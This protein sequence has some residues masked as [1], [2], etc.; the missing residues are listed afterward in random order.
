[1]RALD[2]P[3][4]AQRVHGDLHLGQTLRTT[5]GW[6][7]IDFEG[8]PAAPLA[9]RVALDSVWRDVAGMLR[10]FDYAAHSYLVQT[11]GG[12]DDQ[13]ARAQAWV[14]RN[15]QAFLRGYAGSEDEAVGIVLD[16][17]EIDKALYEY[18]YERDH[19]PDW[20]PIPRAALERM[21]SGRGVAE[22]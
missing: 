12:V 21:L 11:G 3:V 19:R 20:A 5:A 17:Y 8:E 9:E 14:E 16:A 22:A 18:V 2:G 7:L 1:M 15:R 10:S 6:K 13:V 4:L